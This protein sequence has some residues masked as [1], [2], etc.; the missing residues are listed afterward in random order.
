MLLS[1]LPNIL[2]AKLIANCTSLKLGLY[3]TVHL[4]MRTIVRINQVHVC[5]QL[6]FL[7][8]EICLQRDVILLLL[9]LLAF[10]K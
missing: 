10:K 1:I 7:C 2:D 9:F 3:T 6:F 8:F 4:L 5:K